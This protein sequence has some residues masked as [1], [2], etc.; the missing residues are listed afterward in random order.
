MRDGGWGVGNGEW[1][2]EVG[3][4]VG[5]WTMWVLFLGYGLSCYIM[6]SLHMLCNPFYHNVVIQVTLWKRLVMIAEL[7]SFLGK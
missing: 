2:L 1:G 3:M 4:G 7:A 6:F 5:I